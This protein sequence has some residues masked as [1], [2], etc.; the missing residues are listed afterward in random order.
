[1]AN[2]ALNF[3]KTMKKILF[4]MEFWKKK[5]NEMKI[6]KRKIKVTLHGM[7]T[8]KAINFLS[9]E[10]APQRAGFF[11]MQMKPDTSPTL[12]FYPDSF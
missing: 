10:V 7:H 12:Q 4:L 8:L 9:S 1:M 3:I 2:L 5:K 11:S 6:E